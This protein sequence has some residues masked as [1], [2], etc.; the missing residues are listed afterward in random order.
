MITLNILTYGYG[1][2]MITLNILTYACANTC[3]HVMMILET[4]AN[5]ATPT[6]L[7]D[8]KTQ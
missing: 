7:S 6:P 3:Q 2:V 8:A 1:Y 5:L 4:N